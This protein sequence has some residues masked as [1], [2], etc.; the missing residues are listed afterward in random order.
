MLSLSSFIFLLFLLAESKVI[1]S[2]QSH[3]DFLH[4]FQSQTINISFS[5]ILHTH[6]NSSYSSLLLSSIQ[7]LRFASLSSPKPIFIITP[8]KEYEIRAVILC[9]KLH[10]LQ[11]RVRCGGHDYEGL[12]YVSKLPFVIIDMRNLKSISIDTKNKVAWISGGGIGTLVRKYGIAADNIIDA[13]IM[14]VKGDILD[15]KSMGEDL[16]WA[17]RGGGVASFGVLLEWKF[18][19]VDVP[20]IVSAF[21]VNRT[22][23]QNATKIVH[24]WQEILPNFGKDLFIRVSITR[25]EYENGKRTVQVTFESLYLGGV[26]KLFKKIEEIF[27][28]L[29][30]KR[31][32]CSEMSWIDSALYFSMLPSGATLDDLPIPEFA[33]EGLWKKFFVDEAKEAQ[34][35]FHPYGGRMDE[36]KD[37][38]IPFPH[39]KG[40]LFEI[41]HLVYWDEKD[42]KKSMK[43]INWIRNLYDYMTPYVSKSP[44]AAYFNYR[45]LDLGVNNEKR[46]S[47]AQ[48]SIWGIRY[49]KGN[50]FK[51][52]QVKTKVDPENFFRSEQSIP[53]L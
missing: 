19:L 39:R 24:K 51:L 25:L 38:E 52:A 29:G 44:R 23:E 34:L 12:S 36:I 11:I 9:S 28:E 35:I 37:D 50:F 18:N 14:N 27:P 45:D 13:R 42:N 31:E 17:I 20:S 40:N 8:S 53:T 46:S 1:D 26:G 21:R 22:L 48:A 30:L 4:C 7:N 33:L 49:F 3:E 43:F 16:F 6:E 10:G 47:Y 32:D 2:T 5:N 41:Q 15:R